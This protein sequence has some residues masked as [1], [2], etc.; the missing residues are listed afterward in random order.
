MPVT[1]ADIRAAADR[2]RP[3]ITRTPLLQSSL[4]DTRCRGKVFL[5]A[6]CLQQTGSFKIRGAL[7]RLLQLSAEE[8]AA[9]VVAYSSGNH[10]Q[11]VALAGKIAGVSTTIVMPED[12]PAV[13]RERTRRYG[14][15]IVPYNRYTESREE[16]AA[17]IA[18]EKGAVL[19]PPFDDPH[20]IA[21]QGT[22]GLEIA[23]DI[24]RLGIQIDQVL[25]CCSGGGLAAGIAV[26]LDA[27][28]PGTTVYTVEPNGFDDTKRSLTAGSRVSNPPGGQSIC[29]ALLL[30]RPGA[31][32]FPI[33]QHLGVEGVSVSDR[34]AMGAIRFGADELRVVLEPGGAVALAAVLFGTV[35]CKKKTTVAILSGGNVDAEL[36]DRALRYAV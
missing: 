27:D 29:D 20:I 21:G 1:S 3:Y 18:E 16:I 7:N 10:A 31:I 26:A 30:P 14:A 9:G 25:V 17:R 19:V 33:L 24:G 28:H 36:L 13:K 5:K 6:E 22:V 2:L 8:R 34:E 15:E 12:A 4:L 11:G 23:E 35:P 32:T